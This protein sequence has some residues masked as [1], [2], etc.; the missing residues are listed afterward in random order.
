ML[1]DSGNEVA[2]GEDL[3][4]TPD[5]GVHAGAV[6]DGTV[7][8]IGVHLFD[9]KGIA[10][11]VLC[12]PLQIFALMGLDTTTTMD[13]EAGVLPPAEHPC[14]FRR[15]KSFVEKESDGAGAEQDRGLIRPAAHQTTAP[16]SGGRRGRTNDPCR[17]FTALH[18]GLVIAKRILILI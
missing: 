5:L 13:I 9:G 18:R 8:R 3:K 7:R 16:S 15:E 1:G 6:N 2:W 17:N 11:D 4:V 10:D 12:E 14:A